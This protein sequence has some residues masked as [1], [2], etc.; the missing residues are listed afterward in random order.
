[1][2]G[3]QNGDDTRA[4]AAG[5]RDYTAFARCE[6][7]GAA[8]AATLAARGKRGDDV[9]RDRVRVPVFAAWKR[10][11]SRCICAGWGDGDGDVRQRG[12]AAAVPVCAGGFGGDRGRD[13]GVCVDGPWIDVGAE[14]P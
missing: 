4:A 1:M 6:P 2:D 8:A 12:D 10:A 3:R 5:V 13:A 9:V 7:A 11:G 14:V